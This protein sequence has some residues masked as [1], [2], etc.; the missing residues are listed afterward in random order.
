MRRLVIGGIAALFVSAGAASAATITG[1]QLASACNSVTNC[2]PVAGVTVSAANG[3]LVSNT[4]GGVQGIGN[5]G[6]TPGEIDTGETVTVQ[7]ASPVILNSFTLAAFFNGDEFGDNNERGFVTAFYADGTQQQ[8]QFD[9]T[10]EDTAAINGGFGAIVTNC[11]A[12]TSSGAGCFLFAN[13]P[14]SSKL[15]TKLAFT[16]A[17]KPTS[18]GGQDNN[19]DYIISGLQY[20]L[21]Q[22]PIPGALAF[23]LTGLAGLGAAQRRNRKAA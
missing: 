1:A 4:V 23:L 22:V 9:V 20:S 16:A 17:N 2:N 15:I 8:F 10:G 21:S 7:F 6:A 18:A 19:S 13:N 11:G 3:Q 14:L 12:T 5:S